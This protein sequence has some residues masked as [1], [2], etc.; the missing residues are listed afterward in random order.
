MT[1]V[2]LNNLLG[3]CVPRYHCVG[4]I[5]ISIIDVQSLDVFVSQNSLV[6]RRERF[7]RNRSCD[8]GGCN[9]TDAHEGSTSRYSRGPKIGLV[10]GLW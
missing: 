1:K 4:I 6:E 3:I 7:I 8:A 10:S 5:G 9:S 2:N